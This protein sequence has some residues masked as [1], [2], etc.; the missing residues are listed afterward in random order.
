M[1]STIKGVV[2][3]KY[4][5]HRMR[6]DTSSKGPLGPSFEEGTVIVPNTTTLGDLRSQLLTKKK[7]G[8]RLEDIRLFW[9]D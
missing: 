6:D 2:V 7:K 8:W 1:D 3:A 9:P 4:S 5:L